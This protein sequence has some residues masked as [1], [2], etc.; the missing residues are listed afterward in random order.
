[1]RRCSVVLRCLLARSR[2]PIHWRASKFCFP[3]SNGGPGDQAAAPYFKLPM[4]RFPDAPA[5]HFA[6]PMHSRHPG[7]SILVLLPPAV[8]AL[9]RLPFPGESGACGKAAE[10]ATVGGKQASP[11]IYVNDQGHRRP[12][13]RFGAKTRRNKHMP[14]IVWGWILI[15]SAAATIYLLKKA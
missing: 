5:S 14:F 13:H 11:L 6:H 15:G 12:D 9:R 10:C 3:D 8:K 2:S 4:V 1:M 7:F